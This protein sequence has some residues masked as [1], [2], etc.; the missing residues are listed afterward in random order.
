M[1]HISGRGV[2]H[3]L[4]FH[5]GDR[6]CE[7]RFLFRGISHDYHFVKHSR[8]LFETDRKVF[9]RL[10]LP[11]YI[12][13]IRYLQIRP[14]RHLDLE[15]AVDIRGSPCFGLFTQHRSTYQRLIVCFGKHCTVHGDITR[16]GHYH[17]KKQH[18]CT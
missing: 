13:Y 18:Q 3:I 14:F 11:G 10:H 16:L 6:T 4:H 5:Y 12:T 17:H 2:G 15:I 9:L 8:I 1:Y 7:I